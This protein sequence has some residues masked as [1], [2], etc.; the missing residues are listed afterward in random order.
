MTVTAQWQDL[1]NGRGYVVEQNGLLKTG[2]FSSRE[3]AVSW[4]AMELSYELV[5]EGEYM[6]AVDEPLAAE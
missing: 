2:S 5:L 4:F 3:S 1:H 6:E